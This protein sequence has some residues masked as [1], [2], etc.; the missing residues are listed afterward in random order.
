[1]PVSRAHVPDATRAGAVRPLTEK[2]KSVPAG[3]V[4]PEPSALQIL[5]VPVVAEVAVTGAVVL[6]AVVVV[7]AE[8]CDAAPGTGP[9]RKINC[10]KA[11]T[12]RSER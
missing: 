6:D 1:M 8:V 9:H 11:S 12:R 5:R 3:A 4:V 7:D 10:A 2:S